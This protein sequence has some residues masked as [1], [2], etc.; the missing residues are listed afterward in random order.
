MN[1][2]FT[3]V[4]RLRQ[5]GLLVSIII[6][7]ACGSRMGRTG[8][9]QADPCNAYTCDGPGAQL[10]VVY[11]YQLALGMP[12]LTTAIGPATDRRYAPRT[13]QP[14]CAE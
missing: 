13:G 4:S 9:N 6:L 8:G 12:S 7:T 11:H 5:I 14:R 1:G 10:N 2:R 3:G